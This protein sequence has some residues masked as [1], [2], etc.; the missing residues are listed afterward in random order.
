MSLLA[1]IESIETTCNPRSNLQ[2]LMRTQTLTNE[3]DGSMVN[4]AA[5][6]G[7]MMS[8]S[9]GSTSFP[10]F[11]DMTSSGGITRRVFHIAE[12]TGRRLG[13]ISP[14]RLI[15]PCHHCRSIDTL[16][17]PYWI[18]SVQ[19]YYYTGKNAVVVGS[20]HD[21]AVSST[22]RVGLLKHVNRIGLGHDA[23]IHGEIQTKGLG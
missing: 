18:K 14:N 11:S 5:G 6:D 13:V 23:I 10:P 15:E 3:E 17:Q 21:L 9:R 12:T 4:D 19:Q 22:L 16:I 20:R 7:T 2:C 8:G 1:G